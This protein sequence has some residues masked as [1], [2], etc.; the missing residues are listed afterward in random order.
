MLGLKSGKVVQD[1]IAGGLCECGLV[2]SILSKFILRTS[3]DLVKYP[4][5]SIILRYCVVKVAEALPPA[6]H[7]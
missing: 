4:Y 6:F 3:S 1:L 7:A 2:V 5:I